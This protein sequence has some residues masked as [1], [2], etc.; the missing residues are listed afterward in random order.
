VDLAIGLTVPLGQ[1]VFD[2]AGVLDEDCDFGRDT[3]LKRPEENWG[4]FGL[5]E[6]LSLHPEPDSTL[7]LT[8]DPSNLID[9]DKSGMVNLGGFMDG[10]HVR[11]VIPD[12]PSLS[13]VKGNEIRGFFVSLSL[14]RSFSMSL[15]RSFSFSRLSLLEALFLNFCVPMKGSTRL[16]FGVRWNEENPDD[17]LGI[18]RAGK[19]VLD[20]WRLSIPGLAA[21]D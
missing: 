6:R 10:S 1:R 11:V 13:R 5:V 3:C 17:T 15:F 21:C 4:S 20:D 9:R 16:L 14:S 2:K 19:L 12:A 18:G 8:G 7:G